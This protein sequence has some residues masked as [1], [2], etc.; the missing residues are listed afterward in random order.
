MVSLPAY[1]D[2]N[3]VRTIDTYPFEKNQKLIITI[4]DDSAAWQTE[5]QDISRRLSLLDGLQKYRGRLP[6]DLDAEKELAQAREQ[7][8]SK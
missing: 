7:K 2:G 4:L 1:F 5:T 8:Y 6:A 3:T